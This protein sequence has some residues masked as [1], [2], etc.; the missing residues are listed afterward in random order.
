M[1]GAIQLNL[2]S[3]FCVEKRKKRLIKVIFHIK[4]LHNSYTKKLKKTYTEM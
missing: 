2:N 1:K 3:S 4:Q